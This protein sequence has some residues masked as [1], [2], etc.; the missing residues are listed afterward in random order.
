MQKDNTTEHRSFRQSPL[1][2]SDL[3]AQS[4]LDSIQ[5]IR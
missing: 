4:K 1:P 5:R 3:P 2:S